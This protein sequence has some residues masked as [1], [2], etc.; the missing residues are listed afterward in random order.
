MA[1]HNCLISSWRKL[2]FAHAC[3]AWKFGPAG[4]GATHDLLV[5]GRAVE[6]GQLEVIMVDRFS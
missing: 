6:M 4:A 3:G 5:E 1:N 2:H